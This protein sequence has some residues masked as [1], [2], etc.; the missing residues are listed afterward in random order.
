MDSQQRNDAEAVKPIPYRTRKKIPWENWA[1]NTLAWLKSYASDDDRLQAASII[2]A[3]ILSAYNYLQI[4]N[5]A[6]ALGFT[7]LDAVMEAYFLHPARFRCA[8]R[9]CNDC[10]K[11]AR[12]EVWKHLHPEKTESSA[13]KRMCAFLSINIHEFTPESARSIGIYEKGVF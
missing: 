10:E 2:H 12:F 11:C 7:I 8:W 9:A 6:L 4:D 1:A 5:E 3:D 13:R